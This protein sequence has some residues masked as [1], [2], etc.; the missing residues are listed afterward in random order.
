MEW[1]SNASAR[2][3][4]SRAQPTAG[5]AGG[6]VLRL[7]L[8]RLAILRNFWLRLREPLRVRPANCGSRRSRVAT[9]EANL[10]CLHRRARLAAPYAT[11]TA[12]RAPPTPAT[13][14]AARGRHSH[15]RAARKMGPPTQLANRSTFSQF[16]PQT[17]QLT[18]AAVTATARLLSIPKVCS[19]L[20]L[21]L[22]LIKL[23]NPLSSSDGQSLG[24]LA[25]CLCECDEQCVRLAKPRPRMVSSCDA[26]GF[27]AK[28]GAEA[29]A[30]SEMRHEYIRVDLD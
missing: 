20:L 30:C 8:A 16:A 12:R 9:S 11:H 13:R 15:S 1:P 2:S 22:L 28:L 26:I 24:C 6:C 25:V 7:R 17:D 29:E 4:A 18:H 3:S 5:D 19:V 27:G 10:R 14:T 23:T 21:W